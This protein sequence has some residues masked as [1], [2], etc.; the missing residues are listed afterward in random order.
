M[1][2]SQARLAQDPS[3]GTSTLAAVISTCIVC[4]LYN[5]PINPQDDPECCSSVD[6]YTRDHYFIQA[7]VRYIDELHETLLA[8]IRAGALPQ[9]MW[10]LLKKIIDGKLKII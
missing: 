3:A 5:F 4:A 6:D 9:G 10:S 8:R 1:R 2:P 7:A